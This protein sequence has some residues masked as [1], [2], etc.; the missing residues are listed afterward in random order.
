MNLYVTRAAT[1][2]SFVLKH[3]FD[4]WLHCL[5]IIRTLSKWFNFSDH[6]SL[7]EG[8]VTYLLKFSG[9]LN[10]LMYIRYV[11]SSFSFFP[12]KGHVAKPN[13]KSELQYY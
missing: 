6:I 2:V 3:H 7:S 11:V 4:S 8:N 10:E 9:L 1:W 13:L 5:L 12:F